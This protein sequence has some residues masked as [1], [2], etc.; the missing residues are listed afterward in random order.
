MKEKELLEQLKRE[1]ERNTPDLFDAILA[2]C[3]ERKGSVIEMTERDERI[4]ESAVST[5]R[6]KKKSR[7]ILGT[8]AAC[9][10][11][12]AGVLG[13]QQNFAV[14]SVV[15]IDVNPSIELSVSRSEKVRVCRAL[16]D[17]G[18]A[19]LE[20]MNLKG[21]DLSIAVNAIIGSMV[22]NGYVDEARN[23]VLVSVEGKSGQR[24]QALQDKVSAEVD[25]ALK[26][27]PF[28]GAVIGQTI[29]DRSS[30]EE[31][32]E[33]YGISVGKAALIQKIVD[34]DPTKT[35]ESLLS[36][37]ISELA[38]L[39]E[40]ERPTDV[41]TTG[42]VS[43]SRYI[44]EETALGKALDDAGLRKS[45]A[46]R[47]QIHL[48]YDEDAVVYE[49]EFLYAGMEYEY[50]IEAVTGAILKRDREADDD[51]GRNIGQDIG[52]EDKTA[53]QSAQKIGKTR[54]KEIALAHQ[55]LSESDV[56][57]V[58]AKLDEDDG[59]WIYEIEFLAGG[60]EYEYEIDAA[61]G[62]IIQYEADLD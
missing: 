48:D 5:N 8:A 11:L 26:G 9:L 6:K 45:S 59:R 46:D 19:I 36:A 24:N 40:T 20:D 34:K 27:Y 49:I 41:K 18:A 29:S 17:D 47:I 52:Q 13:Y 14:A 53:Q 51:A 33:Q 7:R 61:S 50:E 16:N 12:L 2:G 4:L 62:E 43:R 25:A 38:L 15:G 10:C 1:T 54:A 35:F 21:V 56:R 39:A 30:L 55:K 60:V 32:A 37:G 23:S 31:R 3:E 22:K 58:K 57:F 28:S 42:S 44:D